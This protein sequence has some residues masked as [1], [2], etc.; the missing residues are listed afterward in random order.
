MNE[1]EWK[2]DSVPEEEIEYCFL[3]EYG[4]SSEAFKKKVVEWRAKHTKIVDGASDLLKRPDHLL[5][6]WPIAGEE[7]AS[8]CLL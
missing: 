1:Q 4:R 2:F 6:R 8:V 7:I 3:Y 5:L